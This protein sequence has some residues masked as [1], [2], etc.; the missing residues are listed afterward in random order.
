MAKAE[1]MRINF[2]DAWREAK[3]LIIIHSPV[4]WLKKL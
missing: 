3:E 2:S 4:P 1:R